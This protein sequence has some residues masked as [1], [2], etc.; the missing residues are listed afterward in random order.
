MHQKASKG[1]STAELK[2]RT[3]DDSGGEK[4][5]RKQQGRISARSTQHIQL[6]KAEDANVHSTRPRNDCRAMFSL[7]RFCATAALMTAADG[8]GLRPGPAKRIA[9]KGSP[10]VDEALDCYP[11]V[12]K[13][14]ERAGLAGT[15]NEMARLYGD[16]AALDFVKTMPQVRPVLGNNIM[17]LRQHPVLSDIPQTLKFNKENFEPCLDSWS[18]QFT[19][20]KAQ[21]MVRRNPG[22]LGVRPETT[23]D[24]EASM[25]FS[26]IVAYTRPL[27]KIIGVGGLLAIATA[28]I[29][30]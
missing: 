4:E 28:G 29:N 5:G 27:P 6:F 13:P 20:K 23:D 7:L 3:S 22:L 14:E 30:Q 9:S 21:S 17:R 24:A 11:F 12:I 10:L 8:F 26:Y 2:A 25:L 18:E 16:E 19:L 1:I 15:F